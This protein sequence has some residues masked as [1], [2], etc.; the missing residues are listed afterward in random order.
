MRRA[1]CA[2]LVCLIAASSAFAQSEG[3]LP[4]NQQDF[5]IKEVPGDPGAAA[6]QLYYADFIN[7]NFHSEFFYHRIKV[8]NDRGKKYADVEIPAY[9]PGSVV[10]DLKARTIH[11]DGTI[12]EFKEKPFE[13]TII[14]GRGFKYLARTFTFPAVTAG[15]IIEYKYR[16]ELPRGIVYDN[17]WTIQHDL[18]TV[19]ENFRMEAYSGRLE[20]KSGDSGLMMAYSNMPPGIKPN[21]KNGAFELEVKDMP[22][23]QAE[24]YMP[25]EEDY[26]PQVRFF[27]G[28]REMSTSDM[29]WRDAGHDWY[30]AVEKFIGNH[31][32]IKDAATAA[33]GNETDPDKQLRKLYA[34]AQ[35][36]RNLTYERERSREE[37]K[38]ENLK[39]NSNVVDVLNHGYGYDG[40]IVLFFVALARATGY[41]TSVLRVSNRKNRFFD[42]GLLSKRQLDSQLAVVEVNGSEV[43]L[44]PGT[45]FCPYGFVRWMHTSTDALR[46]DKDGGTFIK[47]PM[48]DH[49]KAVLLRDTKLVLD[50]NGS[51]SGDVAVEYQGGESLERRLDALETDEAGRKKELEDEMKTW[52][53]AA[54]I[55]HLSDVQGWE[56]QDQN[57]VAHFHIEVPGYASAAGK[58]LLFPAGLFQTKQS[59]LLGRDKRKFPVY[60][61][62]AFSEN[63]IINIQLPPGYTL[64][65]TP[66][67]QLASVSYAIYKNDS[68][69]SGSTIEIQRTLLFGGFFFD[70]DRY[71]EVKDFLDQVRAGDEQQLVLR[72]GGTTNASKN[73]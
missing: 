20:T 2:F 61:P 24:E 8:L 14:K 64:E 28:G 48:A 71:S 35:Q 50:P 7:D 22:A 25:P 15:S 34:R 70:L 21:Q 67:P 23:F 10:A 3:W 16:L 49:D 4:I 43:Y 32:E 36:I 38:K 30:A 5:Q 46:L 73:N 45:K 12:I 59:N 41:R 65:G 44:D 56:A 13:K 33:I 55:V 47:V 27:Y 19:K 53:P 42:P 54:A 11:P 68:E 57:L 62:Y 69:L 52:L 72:T 60:F 63:D 1:R 31:K 58:R 17:S 26:K 18:Y 29:F 9:V 39:E 40:D 6:I 37:Q 66:Q 51:V